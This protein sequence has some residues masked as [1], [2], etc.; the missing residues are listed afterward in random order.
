MGIQPYLTPLFKWWWLILLSTLLA[1][2]TSFFAVWNLPLV[3]TSHTTMIIGKTITNPNPSA[4]DFWLNQQLASFY[5]DLSYREP[6][7][8]SVKKALGLNALP[9]YT[10]KP[11]GNNQFLEIDVTDENPQ[12]ASKVASELAHQIIAI[13]PGGLQ[14]TDSARGKF[15][16]EQLAKT[17][18]QIVE[19]ENDIAKKQND[20]ANLL[21]AQDLEKAK[22]DIKTAQ[23]KLVLLQT[24]YS[25]LL[26]SSKSVVTNILEVIEPAN[27]P[28][29]PSGLS[30]YL[31]IAIACAAG[32]V[33]GVG[34]SYLL[35]GVDRSVKTPR[36]IEKDLGLP[37]LGYLMDMGK[38]YRYT[39]YV[40]DH[41]RSMLAEAFRT[42]RANL[43]ILGADGNLRTIMV[44]SPD[45]GDG[46]TSVSV[47]LAIN[48][49]QGGK[50]V[51]LL[52]ADLRR[53]TVHK[54]FSFQDRIGVMDV[55][56]GRVDISSTLKK[57]GD[58]KLS[59]MAAGVGEKI[60]EESFSSE[61]VAAL[62]QELKGMAD[63]VVVDN[64]PIAVSDTLIFASKVDGILLVVRPGF[65]NRDLAKLMKERIESAQGKI[66]GV[67]L[68]RIPITRSGYFGEYRHYIPYYYATEEDNSTNLTQT[69]P[70]SSNKKNTQLK[71]IDHTAKPTF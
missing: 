61:K 32:L 44:T 50:Q 23:E 63:I 40:A 57:W 10:V 45:Q 20:L 3:Y 41:P 18:A 69:A 33:L 4:N 6:V 49:A 68:N 12:L 2:I 54:Y 17:Q 28:T 5:T 7:V 16:D 1:L 53:P 26:A 51:I 29:Q 36:D 64:P 59:V 58:G 35:E 13:S 21:S 39:R 65:T 71:K 22:N 48:L 55:L 9:K 8:G 31:I 52:D 56:E 24:N 14:T 60:S 46:K 34:A 25:N 43:E 66:I 15:T 62:L 27:I 30:K 70:V 19:T 11:L 47:N 38:A 37:I 42:L 67:V